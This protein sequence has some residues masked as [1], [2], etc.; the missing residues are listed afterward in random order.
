MQ[1][2]QRKSEPA[3]VQKVGVQRV[4]LST[5]RT[6]QRLKTQLLYT[7]ALSEVTA[8]KMLGMVDMGGSMRRELQVAFSM[9]VTILHR[10]LVVNDLIMTSRNIEL[11]RCFHRNS[12]GDVK[13][14]ARG[15]ACAVNVA[16]VTI[17]WLAAVLAK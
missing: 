13:N 6:I 16:Q 17:G 3:A 10:S 14:L 1:T 8:K 4:I 7:T 2:N 5:I 11:G 12:Y 15:L 9:Q